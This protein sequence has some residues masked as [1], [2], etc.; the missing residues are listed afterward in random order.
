MLRGVRQGCKLG[1]I[2]F[3]LLLE[4]CLRK[5]DLQGGVDM[6]CRSKAGI[7]CP[8]D[9]I[10][11]EFKMRDGAFADDI[12]LVGPI[13]DVQS[14]LLRLNNV[15][16]SIGLDISKE[17]TEWLWLYCHEEA[18][19]ANVP[20]C[21]QKLVLNDSPI[22]HVRSFVYLGSSIH[23][24]GNVTPEVER[25]LAT[26]LSA[27]RVVDYLWSAEVSRRYKL[28]V[29]RA[30]VLPILLYGCET[31]NMKQADY[32]KIEVFLNRCRLRVA[33]RFRYENGVVLSNV[34]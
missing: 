13:D 18:E 34:E 20:D 1:L 21:C 5:A 33:N 27:L 25:R 10:N 16:K 7:T 6:V 32:D 17:K 9:I 12:Y 28:S 29:L 3:I 23:E 15:C 30:R 26:A 2:L 31:W 19:C 4:F 22:R 14:N 11:Q 8:A 24:S